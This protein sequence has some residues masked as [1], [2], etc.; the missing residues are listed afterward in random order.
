MTRGRGG[1]YGYMPPALVTLP[2]RIAESALSVLG[3]RIG[4]EEPPHTSRKLGDGVEIR[5]Y[6]ARI[7][8][9]TTVTGSEESARSA[10][11]RRL[12]GYIFG[13]NHRDAKIAMTAPVAQQKAQRVSDG[14]QAAESSVR[15]RMT[16]PVAQTAG[17]GDDWVI[18][19]YMPSRWTMDELPSP[20]DD[21]VRLVTVPSQTVAVLRFTGNRDP[22]AVADRTERL[23]NTLRAYGFDVTGE[24]TA[25]FYDPPWTLPFLRRNEVSVPVSAGSPDSPPTS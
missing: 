7:A 20:N 9:E 19:F 16:A 13:G 12:A 5:E 22:K 24:V 14:P 18:R 4:T 25:W 10:G 11:F 23:R 2:Q 21:R 15:I 1:Q 6:E 8:A 17:E 3:V